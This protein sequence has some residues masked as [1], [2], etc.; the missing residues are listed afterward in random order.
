MRILL[1]ASIMLLSVISAQAAHHQHFHRRFLIRHGSADYARVADRGS[2]VAHPAG[3]PRSAFCGCGV[4]N[5]VFGRPVRSLWLVRNWYRFPRAPAVPGNVVLFGTRHVAY[6]EAVNGDGTAMLYDPNSGGGMTRVHRVNIAGLTI[7][8]PQGSG[9][10][11]RRA[12]V[13]F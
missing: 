3:C 12:P 2:I 11:A 7:V 4:S 9:T 5:R 6:I 10:G 13:D 8:S 1:A